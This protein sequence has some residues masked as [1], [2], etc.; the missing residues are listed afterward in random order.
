MYNMLSDD[1]SKMVF[2]NILNFRVSH[3]TR[4]IEK[5]HEPFE[6]QYFDERLIQYK[7]SDVF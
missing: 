7:D 6:C 3:D 4:L 5:I 2:S 1:K